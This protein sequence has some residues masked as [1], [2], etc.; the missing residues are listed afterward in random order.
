MISVIVIL[1]FILRV[2]L[3]GYMATRLVALGGVIG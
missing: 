2:L 1:L 3:S